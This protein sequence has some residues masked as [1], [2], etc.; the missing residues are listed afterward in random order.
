MVRCIVFLVDLWI[1]L[2][3][4]HTAGLVFK[5]SGDCCHGFFDVAIVLQNHKVGV[6]CERHDGVISIWSE[7]NHFIGIKWNCSVFKC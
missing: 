4:G 6:I 1:P 2:K 3:G 5:S 7:F